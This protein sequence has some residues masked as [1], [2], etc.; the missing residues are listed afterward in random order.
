MTSGQR[1]P[2][3]FPWR[4]DIVKMSLIKLSD[5]FPTDVEALLAEPPE[6]GENLICPKCLKWH[7]LEFVRSRPSELQGEISTYRCSHC[8]AEIEF[9]E[10]HP[11]DA[12]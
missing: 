11:P 12:I 6:P 8:D 5:W 3:M 7:S 1:N 4:V 10:C 9:A 2:H